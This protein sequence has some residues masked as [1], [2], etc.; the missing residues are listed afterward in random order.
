MELDKPNKDNFWNSHT[1]NDF[2]TIAFLKNVHS[3][4]INSICF[5]KDGRIVS[6][7]WDTVLI[8]KKH[9]FQIEII[10]KEKGTVY[11]MNINK[12]GTLITCLHKTYLNL[13]E[14]KGKKYKIVQT[15]KPYDLLRDIIGKFDDSF[16]I[17]KFIELENGDIAILVWGYAVSFYKKKNKTKKYSYLNKY[18]EKD[19]RVTDLIELGNK[20]YCLALE[21]A[22]KIQFLDMN[23]K[24]ITE[25]INCN[26]YFSDSHNSLLLMNNNDLLV[27]GQEEILIIDVHK[28]KIIKNIEL[29][30]NGYLSSMYKLS[31]NIILAGYW[32]NY[33]EQLQYDEI[34]KEIKVI[35]R[36]SQISR[37][38]ELYKVASISIF[39]NNYIASPYDNKLGNS[40]IIIRKFKK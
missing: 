20:E 33:I 29:H 27:A 4:Q 11:Y 35:S 19:E 38:H 18:K 31:Y 2:E 14:I 17:L 10:I 40:S 30:I 12:D 1:L 15:I 34:K 22:Q 7:G 16:T 8:Y 21:Y 32:S 25:N 3:Y 23:S 36:T 28:K 5:L 39:N 24:K 37:G 6:S 13:Y 9:T 26:I